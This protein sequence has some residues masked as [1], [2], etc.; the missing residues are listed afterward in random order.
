MDGREPG[1]G[2]YDF[3]ALL[4]ALTEVNYSGWVSLE[5]FDFSR[6]PRQVAARAIDH[7]KACLPAAAAFA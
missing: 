7:L 4:H 2:D 6:D 3:A 1:M 5:A